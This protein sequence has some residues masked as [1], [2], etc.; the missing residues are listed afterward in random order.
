MPASSFCKSSGE[1]NA[2][3]VS[4]DDGDCSEDD[5][6]QFGHVDGRRFGF[7]R[8]PIKAVCEL[9]RNLLAPGRLVGVQ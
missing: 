3:G 8:Q 9:V 4:R 2:G 1:S 7:F 6:V 5:A